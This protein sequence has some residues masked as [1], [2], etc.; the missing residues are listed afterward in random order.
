[1]TTSS[2]GRQAGSAE[3]RTTPAPSAAMTRGGVTRWA[4]WARNR[5]RWLI[6]AARISTATAPGTGSVV[7]RSR[8]RT[9]A[10]P[11]GSPAAFMTLPFMGP[12]YVTSIFDHC[13]PNYNVSGKVCR[14]DG[15]VAS[16]S[17]GGPDPTFDAGYAQTPGGHD[18]LY[19]SGHDGYDYGLYYEP[20]AAAAPRRGMDA[21]WLGPHF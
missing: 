20:V 6:E 12:H 8:T 11:S 4:P 19:Y 13:G 1:M 3:A 10:G 18:Y 16:A 2:P 17:V 7:G 5:S 15:A 21:N 14:Y 9:P